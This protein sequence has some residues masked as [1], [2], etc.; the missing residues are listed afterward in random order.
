MNNREQSDSD[1]A[2]ARLL[3]DALRPPLGAADDKACP[4]AGLLAAYA[5]HS[6]DESET[7]R[8]EKHFADCGRCQKILAVLSVSAEEP[9]T[10]AELADF[11]RKVAA[12]ELATPV[13][14]ATPAAARSSAAANKITPFA[15]PRTAWRWFAPAIGAAAALALWIALRPAPAPLR[16]AGAL[17][18]QQAQQTAQVPA[19]NAPAASAGESLEARANLPAPPAVAER[20]AAQQAK[21]QQLKLSAAAESA[22]EKSL[23]KE[24]AP[25]GQAASAQ[26]P[27]RGVVSGESPIVQ[28][29]PVLQAQNEP[30]ENLAKAKQSDN[31]TAAA[32]PTAVPQAQ[33]AQAAAS[34]A[35]E[36]AQTKP[37][38]DRTV[39]L[40]AARRATSGVGVGAAVSAL[41]SS[42][43]QTSVASPSGSVQ[44]R[45][46]ASG[47]I[48]RSTD[49]GKTWQAQ[50]SGV[51]ND[52]LA[53]AA[54]SDKVAWLVGRSGVI[55]RTIDGEHWQRV[56]SPDPSAD[57]SSIEASDGQHATVIS[58]GQR[59][60]TTADAGQTWKQQ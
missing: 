1:R 34:T 15:Q 53:G 3:A 18:A 49:R 26:E 17:T 30:P 33:T 58:P 10:E 57:W 16:N 51:T 45:F 2:M 5:E 25:A 14:P 46:G 24:T 37:A 47:N 12:A 39:Q 40:F 31:L 20:Q 44:W 4:D 9:L 7:A 8:W 19:A 27:P 36:T 23:K 28:T 50:A 42:P 32:A 21:P 55:L 29:Q 48:E 43:R 41:G 35:S 22:A 56:A 60:F 52:L 54:P 13:T 11:G 59:R 6:L 38:P